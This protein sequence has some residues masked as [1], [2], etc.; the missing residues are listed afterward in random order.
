MKR[1]LLSLSGIVAGALMLSAQ[2][3]VAQNVNDAVE[4]VRSIYKTDRQ[5][6]VADGLRLNEKESAAFWPIYQNYRAEMEKL[7]DRLLNVVLQYRDI[8]PNVSDEQ[9]RGLMRD[10]LDLDEKITSTRAKYMH[11]VAKEVSPA[12]ALRWGQL[13]NRM[14][15]ALRLQLAELIP[16]VPAA[17]ARR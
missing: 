13:E 6:F 3:A 1:I 10:Y 17:Q 14:D 9:A 12:R 4:M 11:K 15:L 8:Y 16:M 7:G 2:H 5:T